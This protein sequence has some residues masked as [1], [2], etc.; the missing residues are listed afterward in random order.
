MLLSMLMGFCTLVLAPEIPPDNSQGNG[1]G[2]GNPAENTPPA[3]PFAVFPTQEAFNERVERASRS[4]LKRLFGTD[5]VKVIQARQA[6]LEQMEKDEAEREKAKMTEIERAKAE[7][8]EAEGKARAAQ[9][10]A[11]RLRLESHIAQKCS[12]LGIRDV[13]YATYLISRQTESL[14][15]D[16]QLDVELFLAEQLKDKSKAVAFG[17][18]EPVV[19]VPTPASTSPD[20]PPAPPPPPPGATG[21]AEK[22]AFEL[23]DVEW[24]KRKSA[25]G[26]A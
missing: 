19:Q 6:K 1:G 2:G 3:K 20:A 10:E 22:N 26:I 14:G 5:D 23:S 15:A 13:G 18:A 11:D 25:L 8:L 9:E 17:I 12:K 21:A 24:Q 7:K 16:E 4:E